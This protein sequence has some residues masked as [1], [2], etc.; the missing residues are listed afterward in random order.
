MLLGALEA[1]SEVSW[2]EN[3][4][5]HSVSMENGDQCVAPLK[6]NAHMTDTPGFVGVGV[7]TLLLSPNTHLGRTRLRRFPF[8]DIGEIFWHQMIGM[9]DV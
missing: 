8:V 9:D 6:S 5:V 4:L 3:D 7:Y 2:A 1:D